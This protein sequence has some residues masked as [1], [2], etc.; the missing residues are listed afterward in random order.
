MFKNENYEIDEIRNRISSL[1][2]EVKVKIG[3]DEKAK[4]DEEN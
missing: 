1:F 3:K 4:E 2:Q